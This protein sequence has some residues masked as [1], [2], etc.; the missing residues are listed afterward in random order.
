MKEL[1]TEPEEA[2][3]LKVCV[4]HL[5]GLRYR[6]QVPYVRLGKSVRYNHERVLEAL[7]KLERQEVA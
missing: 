5:R 6:G 7:Q 1:S 2:K 4:R 3:L